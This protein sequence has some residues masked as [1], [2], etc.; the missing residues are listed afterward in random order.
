V[1]TGIRDHLAKGDAER[2]DAVSIAIEHL[3]QGWNAIRVANTVDAPLL[4]G[5]G[6]TTNGCSRAMRAGQARLAAAEALPLTDNDLGRW[7]GE[8]LAHLAAI[9]REH[10]VLWA[11]NGVRSGRC[12]G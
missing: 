12:A 5:D 7:I 3:P 8:L 10:P 11:P 9:R 6:G 2:R 4:L 1:V